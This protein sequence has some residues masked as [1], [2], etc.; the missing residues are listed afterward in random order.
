MESTSEGCSTPT[1]DHFTR[2]KF[3][4]LVKNSLTDDVTQIS[5]N[6]KEYLTESTGSEYFLS[7][8]E[9]KEIYDLVLK[10]K[11]R[12]SASNRT[13]SVFL[14]RNNDW[15]QKK[16]ELKKNKQTKKTSLNSSSASESEA[17]V[18]VDSYETNF[19]L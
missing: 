12:W 4:Y 2:L 8:E 18:D 6:I 14:K 3:Y 1:E 15:L 9:K 11:A 5:E 19:L 10:I 17:D 7:D 13:E 16:V